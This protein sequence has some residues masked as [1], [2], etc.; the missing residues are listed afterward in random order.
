MRFFFFLFLTTQALAQI[1]P[2]D[3]S[4]GPCDHTEIQTGGTFLCSTLNVSAVFVIPPGT[5]ITIFK[6]KGD[7]SITQPINL[8]GQAGSNQT[9][10]I[11][12]GAG[13]PGAG[14]GGGIDFGG[15]PLPGSDAS[16]SSGQA[17]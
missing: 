1:D 15:I 10:N 13:G 9:S 5:P 14:N 7:V 12:G 2:G 17:A 8:F 6:V 16:P 4:Y 3:G 11:S